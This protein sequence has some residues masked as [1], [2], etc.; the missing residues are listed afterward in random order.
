MTIVRKF[1]SDIVCIRTVIKVITS[2][3]RWGGKF[4]R[5]PENPKHRIWP[6]I[7]QS[8][9]TSCQLHKVTGKL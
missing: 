3:L 5:V 6:N 7:V 9:E 2:I 1:I 4:S 8:E